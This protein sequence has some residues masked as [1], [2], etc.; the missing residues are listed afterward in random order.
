MSAE[1][2]QS[3]WRSGLLLVIGVIAVVLERVAS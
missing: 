2:P 3:N 1:Q